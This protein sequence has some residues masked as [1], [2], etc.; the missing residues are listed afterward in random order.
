[1]AKHSTYDL[2]TGQLELM[3]NF[4]RFGAQCPN[5]PALKDLCEQLRQAMLQKIGRQLERMQLENT[6]R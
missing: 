1:M 4:L 3:W 5:V 2:D 6:A